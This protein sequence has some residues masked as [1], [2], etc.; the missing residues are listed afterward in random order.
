M[1]RVCLV[2][3]LL[4]NL[5]FQ[6]AVAAQD[7]V[8]EAFTRLDTD[9]D[10]LISPKEANASQTPLRWI[11]LADKN[12]DGLSLTEAREWLAGRR[13]AGRGE[14]GRTVIANA[15]PEGAPLTEAGCR[16][17]AEYSAKR[18]GDSILVMV[19]DAVVYEQYE[20]GYTPETPHRL[21]SGTKSFSGA[22]LALAVKDG[23]LILDEP[24][25]QTIVEWKEDES[26]SNVTIRQLLSLTSG[27]DPGENGKVPAYAE[28]IG[29]ES[30]ASPGEKFS[31]GPVPFQVFGELL[32]RKLKAREDLPFSDPVEYLEKRIF[33]PI[34]LEYGNWSRGED[35]MPTL[36]SGAFITP[37][38]W[39]KYGKLLIHEGVWKGEA[40]LDA[41]TLAETRKGSRANSGYGVTFWLLDPDPEAQV[42]AWKRGAYMA[43]GAGKQRLYV[44]PA[45]GVVVVRQGESRKFDD[46][47]FLEALFGKQ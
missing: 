30:L 2:F 20:G 34:G 12:G 11:P 29:A 33:E 47:A 4:V 45:A 46:G 44:L 37:R 8:T 23:L 40:L 27:I 9:N 14:G 16:A 42:L 26:L 7:K 13:N 22:I 18:N 17:A 38:N 24:V 6:Q 43:A 28:A 1:I 39:V 36:P 41:P 15:L 21:A 25:S 32:T 31:Y 10:G 19:D 3:L 5:Y 35:G